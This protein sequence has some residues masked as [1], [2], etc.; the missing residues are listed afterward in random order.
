[1]TPENFVGRIC[2]EFGTWNSVPAMAVPMCK[3][4]KKKK[5]HV[6]IKLTSNIVCGKIN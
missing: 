6:V 4:S 1:M 2:E 5:R 3:E